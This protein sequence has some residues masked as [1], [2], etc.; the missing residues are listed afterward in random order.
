M[1]GGV[2]PE[3]HVSNHNYFVKNGS[4]AIINI[5]AFAQ[6]E[7]NLIFPTSGFLALG[8]R[9]LPMLYVG[10]YTVENIRRNKNLPGSIDILSKSKCCT[11]TQYVRLYSYCLTTLGKGGW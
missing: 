9:Y 5:S 4:S 11:R 6:L 8:W 1:H 2:Y 7:L 10:K 3:R